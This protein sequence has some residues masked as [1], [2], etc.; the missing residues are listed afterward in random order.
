MEKQ[1]EFGMEISEKQHQIVE[2]KIDKLDSNSN[3]DSKKDQE[4]KTKYL[5][6]AA[7]DLRLNN[8][9]LKTGSTP[10]TPLWQQDLNSRIEEFFRHNMHDKAWRFYNQMKEPNF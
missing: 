3:E 1:L 9:S 5:K 10:F 8:S 2:T 4:I 7:K 6:V